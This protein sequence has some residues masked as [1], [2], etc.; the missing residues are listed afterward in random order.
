MIRY[1]ILKHSKMLFLITKINKR[2]RTLILF[3][4]T[5]VPRFITEIVR[6]LEK[7]FPFTAYSV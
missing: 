6:I 3:N 7:V 1:D 5:V 4:V 2:R